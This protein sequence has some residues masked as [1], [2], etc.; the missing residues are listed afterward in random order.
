MERSRSVEEGQDTR[1]GISLTVHLDHGVGDLD[2]VE[3]HG[4]PGSPQGPG[5]SGGWHWTGLVG[6]LGRRRRRKEQGINGGVGG[7]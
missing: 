1:T 2:L 6:V 3:R 4:R 5:E 7:F